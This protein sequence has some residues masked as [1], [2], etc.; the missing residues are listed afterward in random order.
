MDKLQETIGTIRLGIE[1]LSQLNV[2]DLDFDNLAAWPKAARIVLCLLI[3]VV[4]LTLGFQFYLGSINTRLDQGESEELRLRQ[5]FRTK[6][7]L[8][9]SLA[10][11][12][13]QVMTMNATF[14]SLL[15]QLPGDTEVPGLL[16][17]ITA[18]GIGAGLTIESIELQPEIQRDFHIE[19]PINIRVR[20]SYHDLG[21][22]VS[23]VS[24]LPRIVTLHDFSIT[25]DEKSGIL[26]MEMQAR[27]YRYSDEESV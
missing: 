21:N 16:E 20:G 19:L 18:T 2:N 23:G 3:F 9:A 7:A 24:S 26:T 6:A 17:D 27:T 12:R 4:T 11:Y 10:A 1:R 5:V 13:E 25:Q 22:F 8:T 15:R 14:G